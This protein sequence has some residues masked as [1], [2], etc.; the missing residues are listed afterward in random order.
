MNGSDNSGIFIDDVFLAEY[1]EVSSNYE[2]WVSSLEYC[3]G[4][5]FV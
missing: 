1:I 5:K 3:F 2:M 4:N